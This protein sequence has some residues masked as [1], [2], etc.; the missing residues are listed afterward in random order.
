MK[1][2]LLT[3]SFLSLGNLLF[4]QRIT[5]VIKVVNQNKIA[6]P[7]VRIHVGQAERLWWSGQTNASGLVPGFPFPNIPIHQEKI[8]FT[9]WHADLTA[10]DKLSFSIDELQKDTLLFSFKTWVARH[11]TS[12]R[13]AYHSSGYRAEAASSTEREAM[14]GVAP[15]GRT[16]HLHSAADSDV[17]GIYSK[18]T[19]DPGPGTLTAAEVND[20][21]GWPTFSKLLS[22]E[23]IPFT[24]EWALFPKQRITAEVVNA[25]YFPLVDVP[26]SLIDPSGKVV[27][28]SRTDNT[29]RA[30]LWVHVFTQSSDISTNYRLIAGDGWDSEMLHQV[31]P[32]QRGVHRIV[33]Q[34][35][36][37][38]SAKVDVAFVV[39]AT[40]SMGDELHYL[41]TEL[42]HVM[43]R[44]AKKLQGLDFR[45]G[46]VVYR[47]YGDEYLTRFQTLGSAENAQKFLS[48]QRAGG[49]GD[50]PEAVQ[51][52]LAVGL[53]SLGWAEEARAKIMFL[54]L[55]APPHQHEEVKSRIQQQIR[56]AAARG[57]RIIPLAC[58]GISKS[59]EFFLR[60]LAVMS[61]GTYTALTDD[62][63]VGESHLKPSGDKINPQKMNDLLVKIIERY[64]YRNEC[65]ENRTKQKD[66]Q[67]IDPSHI[68]SL[69]KQ[70]DSLSLHPDPT[71]FF[72]WRIFPNPTRGPFTVETKKQSGRIT[73][74][75]VNGRLI[76]QT[77]D[78]TPGRHPFDFSQ[79]SRGIYF[80][81]FQNHQIKRCLKFILT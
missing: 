20:L 25:D 36:C 33:L 46:A 27:W 4:A 6:V 29:G 67:I 12:N 77:D 49:G 63:G 73:I 30:E 44:V 54:V 51:E 62:S 16:M 78:L 76:E 40:G 79:Y 14:S 57:I 58:S 13:T 55:D 22:G 61:G 65:P 68:E 75:D 17:P 8:W 74:L 34:K 38:A 80:V 2:H 15:S 45:T 21:A 48:E 50:Y 7:Q 35:S 81:V 11:P 26:V 66:N 39:D 60:S 1:W 56:N 18:S 43:S 59:T 3:V 72:D 64:T 42:N 69:L 23:F 37:A 70:M 47:D 28:A 32:G 71:I 24:K 10:P 31:T 41:T 53:D 19:S 9:F 5:P 52:G